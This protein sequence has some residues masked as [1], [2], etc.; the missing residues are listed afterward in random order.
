MN[1][2]PQLVAS[3]VNADSPA[4]PARPSVSPNV[5]RPRHSSV[6]GRSTSSLNA[7]RRSS[8]NVSV[9]AARPR[10]SLPPTPMSV[11]Q[12]SPHSPSPRAS[13][14]LLFPIRFG[15]AAILTAPPKL[16]AVIETP[17]VA[18]GAVD[19]R[20]RR[21]VTAT[22]FSSRLGADRRVSIHMYTLGYLLFFC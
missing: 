1:K 21:V 12:L 11:G 17:D 14:P 4:T 9:S 5:L 13:T 2:E 18:V 7:N 15:R 8:L 22:R 3:P 10:P 16:V 20:K 6:L 19:P